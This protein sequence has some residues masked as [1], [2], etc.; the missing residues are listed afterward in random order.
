MDAT[1]GGITLAGNSIKFTS[2]GEVVVSALVR[3]RDGDNI[4]LLFSVRDTGGSSR[5]VIFHHPLMFVDTE[6]DQK[7]MYF[8]WA[9]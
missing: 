7:C 6:G 8:I 2:Q 9:L 1:Y 5:W 3:S 4:E